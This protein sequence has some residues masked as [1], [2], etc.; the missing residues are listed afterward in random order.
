MLVG[1]EVSINVQARINGFSYFLNVVINVFRKIA[2]KVKSRN[3]NHG[4]SADYEA[5]SDV[6]K[7]WWYCYL[8]TVTSDL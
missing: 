6:A 5:L 1:F 4:E 2:Q 8:Y 7:K 3:E